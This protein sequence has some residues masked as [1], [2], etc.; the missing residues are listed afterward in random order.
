MTSA[1]GYLLLLVTILLNATGQLLLKRAT[2]GRAEGLAWG[3]FL[4]PW[5][6]GGVAAQVGTMVA[7]LLTLRRLPLTT[8]H[9]LTGSVFVLVPVAAHLLWAEPLGVQRVLGIGV[10][11]LGIAVVASAA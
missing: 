8:A 7:W 10:I 5:F 1:V 4:N 11:A 3:V 2:V 6:V 9:P